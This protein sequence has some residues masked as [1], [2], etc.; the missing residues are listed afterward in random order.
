MLIDIIII[1][2]FLTVLERFSLNKG[3]KGLHFLVQFGQSERS[4][5]MPF[6]LLVA[7][8][9]T[10]QFVYFYQ[11]RKLRLTSTDIR[12]KVRDFSHGT[13]AEETKLWVLIELLWSGEN[14]DLLDDLWILSV[15][16][17]ILKCLIIY[18][19]SYFSVEKE[20]IQR[21]LNPCYTPIHWNSGACTLP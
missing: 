20:N 8:K 7:T 9:H 3:N 5:L 6:H 1:L 12:L 13:K 11:L 2:S 14:K 16:R 10:L 19:R 4:E 15:K 18:I 17:I 21:C